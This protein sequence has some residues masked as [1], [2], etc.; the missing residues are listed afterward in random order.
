M[1]DPAVLD[2]INSVVETGCSIPAILNIRQM[3]KTRNVDGISLAGQ[4][5][6]FACSVW[7]SFYSFGLHQYYSFSIIL[8]WAFFYGGETYL[9]FKFTNRGAYLSGA[10]K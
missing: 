5:Y 7:W 6:Y 1:L 9:V 8:V 3:L 2:K 10:S 4:T